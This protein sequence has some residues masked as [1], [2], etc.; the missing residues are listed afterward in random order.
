MLITDT[1]MGKP[2][3]KNVNQNGDP[4]DTVIQTQ[5]EHSDDHRL[6]ELLLWCIL[7]TVVLQLAITLYKQ[8][9]KREKKIALNAARSIAALDV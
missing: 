1:T 2:Q 3:S 4:Q 8:L 9:K 5:E 6:Q 7:V